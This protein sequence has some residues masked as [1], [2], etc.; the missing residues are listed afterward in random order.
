MKFKELEAAFGVRELPHAIFYNFPWGLR[1]DLSDVETSSG[2]KHIERFLDSLKRAKIITHGCLEHSQNLTVLFSHHGPKAPVPATTRAISQ[3][4]AIG[5]D[6]SRLGYLGAVRQDDEFEDQSYRHWYS[7]RLASEP[8]EIDKLLWNCIAE[9]MG[10]EPYAEW[11][12]IHFVDF[13]KRM[14]VHVYDDR[15]M[16]VIAMD[17]GTIK[18]FYSKFNDWLLDYDR[19]KMDQQFG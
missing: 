15:G 18:P 14:I 1:F 16:D 19:E 3:L 2:T 10:V 5:F 6:G 12:D 4:E 11:A 13:D 17:K 8:A 9:D 7:C